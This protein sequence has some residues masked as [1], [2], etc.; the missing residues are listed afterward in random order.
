[1]KKTLAL[2]TLMLGAAVTG[3]SSVGYDDPDMVETLTIDFGS[4]DLQV[5]AASMAESMTASPALSYVQREQT[6]NNQDPRVI[7]Y[8][9]GIENRTTEHIDTSGIG[10]SIR[11]Q[12]LKTGK[13]R[14]VGGDQG[15]A[16]IGGQVSFQQGSG[17]VDPTQ[18]KA[19]GKQLGADLV[20]Y[21]TLR[22]INKSKDSSIESLGTS[23]K[24]LYYQFIM[25]CV[26]I[27]T[28]EILWAEEEDIRKRERTGIF[29]R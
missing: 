28:G 8:L 17:R 15:Q 9:G 22:S 11:T 1:M 5:L 12:L 7:V 2:L 26:N 13:F 14:F 27:E 3:C 4:T 6:N 16:E 29:G 24:D 19:F 10:E 23:K 25:N 21:G 18:A 20:V